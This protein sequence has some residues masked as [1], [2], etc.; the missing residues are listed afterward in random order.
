MLFKLGKS[1]KFD[2]S[3]Q[4]LTSAVEHSPTPQSKQRT[5]NKAASFVRPGGG[6][7][8]EEGVASVPFPYSAEGE[9]L[10]LN[11]KLH[12]PFTMVGC[13]R[14]GKIHT[15]YVIRMLLPPP[16]GV[17]ANTPMKVWDC[18]KRYSAFGDLDRVLKQLLPKRDMGKLSSLPPKRFIHSFEDS[19]INERK[20]GL[21][22]YLQNALKACLTCDEAARALAVF[23]ELPGVAGSSGQQRRPSTT[24]EANTPSSKSNME[25][26]AGDTADGGAHHGFLYKRGGLYQNKPFKMAFCVLNYQDGVFRFYRTSRP[27]LLGAVNLNDQQEAHIELLQQGEMGVPDDGFGL[28]LFTPERELIMYSETPEDRTSWMN[29]FNKVLP[30]ESQSPLKSVKSFMLGGNDDDQAEDVQELATIEEKTIQI[31]TM[32]LDEKNAEAEDTKD[33]QVIPQTMVPRKATP[34]SSTGPVPFLNPPSETRNTQG[35]SGT[36]QTSGKDDE[37]RYK[38][39]REKARQAMNGNP[40]KMAEME[41]ERISKIQEDWGI[42]WDDLEIMEKVGGGAFGTVYK[43]KYW[44]TEVAVKK[45]NTNGTISKELKLALAKEVGVLSRLRHPN[46]LLYIGAAW[47]ETDAAMVT[48]WCARRSLYDMLSDPPVRRTP[49]EIKLQDPVLDAKL[50]LKFTLEICRGMC[51]L[52][53]RK[54]RIIHRDLK[55]LNVLITGGLEAKVADF[56]LTVM[57]E[58]AAA[59]KTGGTH[60]RQHSRQHS[61]QQSL[62]RDTATSMV[63]NSGMDFFGTEGTA[64]WMAPEVMEG[65]RYNHKVDVYSFGI[66]LSEILTR[67]FPFRDLYEG[68]DFV[69]AVLD[70]AERPSLPQW[71]NTENGDV[72]VE[73]DSGDISSKSTLKSDCKP[74]ELGNVV[75]KCTNRDPNSR[76]DFAQVLCT[77]ETLIENNSSLELFQQ[78]DLPRLGEWLDAGDYDDVVNASHELYLLTQDLLIRDSFEKEKRLAMRRFINHS[79]LIQS[80]LRRLAH[81]KAGKVLDTGGEYEQTDFPMDTMIDL[82]CCIRHLALLASD[83]SKVL[84]ALIS[85][86][87][88][89]LVS[90]VE[91]FLR[92]ELHQRGVDAAGALLNQ[93]RL[94]STKMKSVFDELVEQKLDETFDDKRNP[95]QRSRRR[96]I[97]VSDREALIW[98]CIAYEILPNKYQKKTALGSAKDNLKSLELELRSMEVSLQSKRRQFLDSTRKDVNSDVSKV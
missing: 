65:G 35:H 48:E 16:P 97:V 11:I 15:Q 22:D 95:M 4:S 83:P 9:L 25:S 93:F 55:S 30:A 23:L 52:H 39:Q 8:A 27:Q 12:I 81:A 84:Q 3:S 18:K 2:D 34:V 89:P 78:F 71:A 80:C 96:T 29:A 40:L 44:G 73:D 53:S 37:E 14:S 17:A 62:H 51:Y 20:R 64:Q 1:S 67:K 57:R 92:P 49:G 60:S 85:P 43:G 36:R 90:V 32:E 75:F 88:D 54:E 82:I 42:E 7:F 21:A 91:L 10:G 79:N 70:R 59:Q 69:D 41:L 87:N 86:R 77:I 38:K 63:S 26:T 98:R 46:I 66:L 56:G 61:T 68:L 76:P 94:S 33:D 5:L 13:E 72:Q 47:T 50:F 28:R 58:A 19:V 74:S 31:L 45:L 6:V 24:S